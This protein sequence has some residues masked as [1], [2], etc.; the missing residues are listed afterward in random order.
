MK[1]Y[2]NDVLYVNK[3][4][5]GGAKASFNLVLNKS[6]QYSIKI[7]CSNVNVAKPFRLS[8]KPPFNIKQCLI[9]IL[10]TS[11]FEVS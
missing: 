6:S 8:W 7:E 1:L 10:T 3:S 2:I 11:Y 9:Y 4:S 5:S